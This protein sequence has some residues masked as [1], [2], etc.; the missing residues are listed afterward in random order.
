VCRLVAMAG[1]GAVSPPVIGYDGSLQSQLH[2]PPHPDGGG[3]AADADAGGHRGATA[4]YSLSTP[5]GVGLGGKPATPPAAAAE[6]CGDETPLPASCSLP[7]PCRSPF[8][9]PS[10]SATSA[11]SVSTASLLLADAPTQALRGTTSYS[12]GSLEASYAG[13]EKASV[14]VAREPATIPV[15]VVGSIASLASTADSE[16]HIEPPRSVVLDSAAISPPIRTPPTPPMATRFAQH[17]HSAGPSCLDTLR[18]A[19]SLITLGFDASAPD[20]LLREASNNASTNQGEFVSGGTGSVSAGTVTGFTSDAAASNCRG[21]LQP[22]RSSASP[23]GLP[24]GLLTTCTSAECDRREQQLRDA[25]L[26]AAT[27][28]ARCGV[29]EE[30]NRDLRGTVAQLKGLLQLAGRAAGEV[31]GE[32]CPPRSPLPPRERE[33]DGEGPRRSDACPRGKR[34]T[35]SRRM[36]WREADSGASGIAATAEAALRQAAE[37]AEAVEAIAVAAETAL[38]HAAAVEAHSAAKRKAMNLN[39]GDS[40]RVSPLELPHPS[41]NSAGG[42]RSIQTADRTLEFGAADEGAGAALHATSPCT[43]NQAGTGLQKTISN[44]TFCSATDTVTPQGQERNENDPPIRYATGHG[45]TV[46]MWKKPVQAELL[47]PWSP[48][49]ASCHGQNSFGVLATG[50]RVDPPPLTLRSPSCVSHREVGHG[51]VESAVR[52]F[53][54]DSV[55]TSLPLP[56]SSS[57]RPLGAPVPVATQR[58]TLPT[59]SAVADAGEDWRWPCGGPFGGSGSGSSGRRPHRGGTGGAGTAASSPSR[60]QTMTPDSPPSSGSGAD[61]G[62]RGPSRYSM[63][64]ICE[65]LPRDLYDGAAARHS[66][67]RPG[68]DQAAH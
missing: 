36:S 54:E 40:P 22:Q 57:R 30:E 33:E 47:S 7:K 63:L 38:R 48:D 56:S 46:T 16:H 9:W 66:H 42:H 19:A 23:E 26:R 5:R 43:S 25:R 41:L 27:A 60:A 51:D 4:Y 32:P 12:P 15:G 3:C 59:V 21:A 37:A 68:G 14:T 20:S 45:P 17:T 65:N 34:P 39:G 2:A 35:A 1:G 64:R 58:E 24:D 53:Q 11:V 61:N 28:E 31:A 50:S 55:L 52:S 62:G 49:S 29:L 10:A 18:E 67:H 13:L 8:W 44:P 6:L